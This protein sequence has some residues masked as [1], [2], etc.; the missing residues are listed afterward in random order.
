MPGVGIAVRSI[1]AVTFGKTHKQS[2][3]DSNSKLDT[4]N[5]L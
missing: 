1:A 4:G 3:Q 5:C 2:P